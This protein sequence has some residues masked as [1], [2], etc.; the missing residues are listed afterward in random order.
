MYLSTHIPYKKQRVFIFINHLTEV[1]EN[2]YKWKGQPTA[3]VTANKC[4]LPVNEITT[5]NKDN[6]F[7][8]LFPGYECPQYHNP[9]DFFLDVVGGDIKTALLLDSIDKKNGNGKQRRGKVGM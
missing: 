2:N 7:Y 9:P 1:N 5:N 8:S 6:I 4:L 3:T